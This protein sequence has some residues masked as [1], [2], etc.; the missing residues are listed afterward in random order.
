MKRVVLAIT[1]AFVVSLVAGGILIASAAA[2]G[3]SAKAEPGV[4]VGQ[5]S[6]RS[7]ERRASRLS[8]WL[9]TGRFGG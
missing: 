5:A 8:E 7:F 1:V 4:H 3:G 9:A 6:V 2:P